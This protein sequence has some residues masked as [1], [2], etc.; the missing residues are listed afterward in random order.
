MKHQ[1]AYVLTFLV[2]VLVFSVPSRADSDGYFCASKSYLAYELREGI[3]PGV[4]GHVLKVVRFDPQRG[5]RSAGGV[6]LQDFQVHM[7]TCGE[8]RIE[9]AGYGTVPPGNDPPLTKCVIKVGGLQND[10]STL[11]CNDDA[12]VQHDWRKEGPAPSNL[13]QRGRAKSIPLE[14]PDPDHK[15]YLQLDASNKKVGGN[16]WEMH[17]KTELIQADNQGKVSQRFLVYETRIVAS[18]SGD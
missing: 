9:I 11:E 3:T 2:M 18:D 13:G 15:Y 17:Y 12:T 6:T 7:M 5:I 16:S 1:T 4:V 8:E 10:P 14:S